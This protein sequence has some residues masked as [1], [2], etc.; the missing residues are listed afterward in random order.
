MTVNDLDGIS[1]CP[2]KKSP[3]PLVAMTLNLKITVNPKTMHNE[4]AMASCLISSSYPVDQPPPQPAFQSHFCSK[5]FTTVSKL[6]L[7]KIN[8]YLQLLRSLQMENGPLTTT[9]PWERLR[10]LKPPLCTKLNQKG[11]CFLC[12]SPCSLKQTQIFW[13]ATTLPVLISLHCLLDFLF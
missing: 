8:L 12:C 13:S 7:F 1:V 9:L 4:I 3:P 6:L 2:E 11:L 10:T 5:K